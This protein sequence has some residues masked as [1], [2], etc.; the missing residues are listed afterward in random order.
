MK[1][2][3]FVPALAIAALTLAGCSSAA[4]PAPTT[5]ETAEQKTEQSSTS[6]QDGASVG[7]GEAPPSKGTPFEP[8]TAD[9]EAVEATW[10]EITAAFDRMDIAEPEASDST[11]VCDPRGR[12]EVVKPD[13]GD[14]QFS[15]EWGNGGYVNW[16]VA[17]VKPLVD[18]G[19]YEGEDGSAV[20]HGELHA[21]SGTV[22]MLPNTLW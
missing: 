16:T 14:I 22:T 3:I 19:Y 9:F 17:G 18:L 11:L 2:L 12:Y 8:T 4:D 10:A 6:T 7:V 13:L 1:K 5:P 20:L 21:A 15:D